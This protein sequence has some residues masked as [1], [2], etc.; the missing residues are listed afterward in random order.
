MNHPSLR[1][2]RGELVVVG[3]QPD[4]DSIRF[5]P[6][7]PRAFRALRRS[8]RIRPSRLDGSVQLR[9][10]AIDTPETHYGVLAQPLGDAARD[11]LLALAGFTAIEHDPSGRADTVTAA[12]PERIPAAVLSAMAD[13]N[14][15]PVAFLLVGDDLPADGRFVELTPE[16]VARSLNAALLQDGS[17]YLTLYSSLDPAPAAQLREIARSARDRELGVW[18]ADATAE[19]RLRTQ[20][21][22]GPDG[23][24]ILPKLFRRCSDYLRT[25]T[26]G[27]T[28]R[29]WL[30]THG[31]PARPEDDGVLVCG[32]ELRLSDLVS[33]RND[34]IAFAADLLELVF[35]EK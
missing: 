11:R 3:K 9:L 19:F 28:L 31:D 4:G 26:P 18:A 21:D 27:E 8:Q 29:S 22:I 24:L 30:R 35:L 32:L 6:A 16:L 14:G 7:D 17:A 15:R 5:A 10:E 1:C 25:R 23:A 34:E 13:A 2:L 12:E 33:Q 20:D